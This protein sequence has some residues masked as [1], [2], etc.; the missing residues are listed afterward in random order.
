MFKVK[1]IVV[2]GAQGV[3][4]IIDIESRKIGGEIKKY[5]VLKPD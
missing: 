3:C 2:Y 4:E 1:D 5:F